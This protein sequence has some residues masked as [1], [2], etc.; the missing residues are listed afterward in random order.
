MPSASSRRC[1]GN[2]APAARRWT[3]EQEAD[4]RISLP[5]VVGVIA[6]AL[7]ACDG[8]RAVDGEC[9]DELIRAGFATCIA[10]GTQAACVQAG[11]TWTIVGL[12]SSPQ[13]RCPTGEGGCPCDRGDQC[14][15]ACTA[16]MGPG[17]DPCAGVSEGTCTAASPSVGCRCWFDDQ[18]TIQ[19]LCAD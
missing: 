9:G 13:C 15:G 2:T 10:A 18:G 17:N 16:E 8:G 1:D 19:S 3:G 12:G 4:L 5:I 11:G 6:G 14:L 7:A